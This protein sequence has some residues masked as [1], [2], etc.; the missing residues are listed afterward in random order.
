[1]IEIVKAKNGYIIIENGKKRKVKENEL[2][3]VIQSLKK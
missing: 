1:M 2:Q 3:S